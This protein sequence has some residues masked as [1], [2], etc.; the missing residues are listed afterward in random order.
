METVGVGPNDFVLDPACGTGGFLVVRE[1]VGALVA[2]D[3][4]NVVDAPQRTII[5]DARGVKPSDAGAPIVKL[6]P[7]KPVPLEDL[8]I[9][10]AGDYHSLADEDPGSTP[11]ASCADTENGVAGYYDIPAELLYRDALTIAFNGS[12][13][14]TKMHPYA[15]GAKDDVAVAIPK[16]GLPVEALI[17]IQA[18]LNAE[19]WRFSYYR[20]CFC[21][22]L[23]RTTVELP[24]GNDG[25]LDLSFMVRAVRAQ[26]Y[27]WFL[28][29]RLNGW[30]STAPIARIR[31][32]F[33]QEP[34]VYPESENLDLLTAE[35]PPTSKYGRNPTNS[36]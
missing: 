20:K 18:Q 12:P 14:T 32:T 22:K 24:V 30:K 36:N 23:G 17:F 6:P 19:R 4:K 31:A 27:W 8:F 21:D 2:F 33:K 5:D 9:L 16:S 3:L 26:P 13:L 15:F 11:V 10:T 7:F 34:M 25:K 28:A 29:P 35:E 1:N